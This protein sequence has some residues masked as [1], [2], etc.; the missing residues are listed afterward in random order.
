MANCRTRN[1]RDQWDWTYNLYQHF[2]NPSLQPENDKYIHH[3][4]HNVYHISP[5][6]GTFFRGSFY[7]GGNYP[8]SKT[9]EDYAR[10]LKF[11]TY[12]HAHVVLENTAFSI[13]EPL[14]LPMSAFFICKNQQIFLKSQSLI[15]SPKI[16]SHILSTILRKHCSCL[17]LGSFKCH[18]NTLFTIFT[19]FPSRKPKLSS[20][21]L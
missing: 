11:G 20:Y 14:L 13:R 1:Y 19:T 12:V 7:G 10:N 8:L 21:F 16:P 3:S 17:Y 6:L 2:M 5:D 18:W 9:R 15:S 4:P